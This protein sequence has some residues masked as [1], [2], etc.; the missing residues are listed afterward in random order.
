MILD[1]ELYLEHF[2]VKGMQWGVRKQ[3]DKASRKERRI[4]KFD[5]K[6]A[7]AQAELDILNK[8]NVNFL[9]AN[10]VMKQKAGLLKE[11]SKAEQNA[12]KVKQGKLTSGKKKALIGAGVAVGLL[13]TYGTYKLQDSGELNRK[14]LQGKNFV[15]NQKSSPWHTKP[16]L[17]SSDL[18]V[19]EILTKVVRHVN[20]EYGAIGTKNNCRRCTLAYEMRRRGYDVSATKS[21]SGAGQTALGLTNAT[22]PGQKFVKSERGAIGKALREVGQRESGLISE[23]SFVNSVASFGSIGSSEIISK[24]RIFMPHD[25]FKALSVNPDGSRGELGL[26]WGVG[27]GHSMAWE[28]IKGKPTIF[29]TQ[30]GKVFAS[31][32]D[33]ISEFGTSVGHAGF[34]RLD[35]LPMNT[36]FLMR[37]LKDA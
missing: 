34:T 6:A 31:A 26:K 30:N 9:N 14:I 11:K 18:N 27:G 29:D 35:N 37:W 4:E 1:E 17:A 28:I 16:E 19:D 15:L 10:H 3:Q 8:K 32:E 24:E 2:G 23:A 22:T 21:F 25:I 33:F 7:S 12:E 5:K 36:D 13:A 20:P